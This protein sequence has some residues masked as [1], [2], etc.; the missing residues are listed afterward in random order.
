MGI[1]WVVFAATFKMLAV[2]ALSSDH[3]TLGSASHQIYH[4]L[5]ISARMLVFYLNSTYII[6]GKYETNQITGQLALF[7]SIR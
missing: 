7:N 6:S 3:K 4:K 2:R 1:K 5:S